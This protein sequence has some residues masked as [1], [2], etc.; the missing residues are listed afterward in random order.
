MTG[1]HSGLR[2]E[3]AHIH[4]A[5]GIPHRAKLFGESAFPKGYTISL[6]ERMPS[7]DGHAGQRYRLS[8]VRW[9]SAQPHH[10]CEKEEFATTPIPKIREKTGSFI[11]SRSTHLALLSPA[12]AKDWQG[13]CLDEADPANRPGPADRQSHCWRGCLRRRTTLARCNALIHAR[14]YW[15]PVVL[16]Y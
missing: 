7:E 2:V 11:R 10:S 6:P 4:G 14:S 5:P 8:H 1:W 13:C 9:Q 15:N 3:S 16:D 12:I